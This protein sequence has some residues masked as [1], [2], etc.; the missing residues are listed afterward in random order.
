MDFT[1]YTGNAVALLV[2][3]SVGFRLIGAFDEATYTCTGNAA[4]STPAPPAPREGNPLEVSV[5]FDG[6]GYVH[7]YDNSGDGPHAVDHFAIEEADPRFA[8]GFGDLSVHEFATDP[9][10]N[11]AYSSYYAGGVRVFGFGPGGLGERGKFIDKGGNNFWGIEYFDSP[12]E[13]PLMAASDR[14]F[15]LYLLRY[16]GPASE[17]V[18]APPECDNLSEVTVGAPVRITLS[19][20][21]PEKAALTYRLAEPAATGGS[22]SGPV[23]GAVTYTPKADFVGEDT[24]RYTASNGDREAV[25][26][27][28][29]VKVVGVPAAAPHPSPRLRP[30]RPPVRFSRARARTTSSPRR[31]AIWCAARRPASASPAAA[32]TTSRTAA[33][34][35]TACPG[36][37]AT[38]TSPVTTAT[39]TSRAAADATTSWAATASTT[40]KAAPATT[41]SPAARARIA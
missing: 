36:K 35:T 24:F 10:R 34:A 29:R 6:W 13:G 40:S 9:N 25:P 20:T 41:S 27:T 19:C 15:G 28:V 5:R 22:V 11:L 1:N 7:L 21:D 39:T 14:D 30:H 4:T 3:R 32:A 38:T 17:P 12:V 37:P 33:A 26:A 18:V 23:D 16:T 8:T 2:G 31:R